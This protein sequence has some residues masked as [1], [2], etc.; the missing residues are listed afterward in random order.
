MA[1]SRDY[2]VSICQTCSKSFFDRKKGIICS[3]TNEHAA[4]EK[5]CTD[6]DGEEKAIKR[7]EA[8]ER[9]KKEELEEEAGIFGGKAGIFGGIALVTLAVIVFVVG[10]AFMDR[11][12]FY[13]IFLLVGGIISL[14]KGV[15][16]R[17]AAK[18][19]ERYDTL[20]GDE[21]I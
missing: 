3:L 17:E 11:I 7:Q 13:P 15:S 20:D 10:L 12:F 2:Y 9:R 16:K 6:Y 5:D 21:I 8:N 1:H 14:S 4:F 19:R 18:K